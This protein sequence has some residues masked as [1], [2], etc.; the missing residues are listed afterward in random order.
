MSKKFVIIHGWEATPEDNWFPWLKEK[1]ES[2]GHE[3]LAP[4]MPN[5]ANPKLNEWLGHLQSTLKNPDENTFL[6]GHSLGCITIL[7]YLESLPR[8]TKIGGAFLVAGF[9]GPIGFDELKS[10]VDKPLDYE[11]I[12]SQTGKIIAVHSDDDSLVPLKNGEIIKEK[13]GAKLIVLKNK[14]HF[15]ELELPELFEL[16]K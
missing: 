10:F 3:V 4:Q 13:L 1:L 7:R 15:N 12:K 5:T 6:I 11:K 14:R 8:N 9:S 2:E 16:T